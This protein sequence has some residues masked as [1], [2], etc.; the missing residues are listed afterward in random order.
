MMEEKF[1]NRYRK[2]ILQRKRVKTLEKIQH[3]LLFNIFYN[4]DTYP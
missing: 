2:R 3:K 4:E 1:A